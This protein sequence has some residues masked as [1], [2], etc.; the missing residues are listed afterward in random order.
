MFYSPRRWTFIGIPLIINGYM[1]IE[2]PPLASQEQV[3][4]AHTFLQ[5][6]LGVS[7]E[8]AEDLASV[9]VACPDPRGGGAQTTLGEFMTS[10]HAADKVGEVLEV[11]R[12]EIADGA[13]HDKAIRRALGAASVTVED[14]STGRLVRVAQVKKN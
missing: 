10:E 8:V 12:E 9:S 14:K 2:G 4:E 11:M 7:P 3:I 13:S 6:S 1:S 5:E